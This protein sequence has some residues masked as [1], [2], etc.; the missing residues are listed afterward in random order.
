MGIN[1]GFFFF[2]R[3]NCQCFLTKDI[4]APVT[5]TADLQLWSSLFWNFYFF[6]LTKIFL[7]LS[8]SPLFE[9]SCLNFWFCALCV[10]FAI[11]WLNVKSFFWKWIHRP[12]QYLC[13]L[14]MLT[15]F[16]LK[17][18]KP[19]F[20]HVP[21]SP[22]IIF[23]MLFSLCHIRNINRQQNLSVLLLICWTHT[24]FMHYNWNIKSSW[25]WF[26]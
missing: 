25:C 6:F 22:I 17:S 16:K 7:Q 9:N 18:L 5:S 10:C 24:V 26:Q 14:L 2:S 11:L 23:I 3:C 20:S 8:K 12:K 4:K 1:T 19:P 15:F 13:L 21:F